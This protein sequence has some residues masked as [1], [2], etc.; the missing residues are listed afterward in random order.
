MFTIP[1]VE[2]D[3]GDFAVHDVKLSILKYGGS[4]EGLFSDI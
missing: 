2:G 4:H 1:S 3:E